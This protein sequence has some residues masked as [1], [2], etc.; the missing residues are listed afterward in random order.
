MKEP[1]PIYLVLKDK[2]IAVI[3]GGKVAERK[4][5]G[6]LDTG[7]KITVIAPKVTHRIRSLACEGKLRLEQRAM[8]KS[9]L[10]GKAVV[11]VATD[12]DEGNRRF[13]SLARESGALVNCV[14]TPEACDFFV[15][16]SFRRGSLSFAISTGGRIPALAKRMREKLQGIFGEEYAEYVELLA[17]GRKRIIEQPPKGYRNK[18]E[19]IEQLIDIDLL[20]LLKEGKKMEALDLVEDV[21]RQNHKCHKPKDNQ[22]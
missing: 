1:Y 2:P 17:M 3:G 4:I 15:P 8:I 16:S 14:D 10:V 22:A 9:D 13:S 19:L 11:F 21:L 20:P 12:S 5:I 7:A 18:K 6:L